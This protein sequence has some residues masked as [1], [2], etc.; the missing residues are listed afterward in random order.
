MEDQ[1]FHRLCALNTRFYRQTAASF[2]STRRSAWQGWERIAEIIEARLLRRRESDPAET[3]SVIDLAC[4]NMRFESFLEQRLPNSPFS[5]IA[6]DNCDSFPCTPVASP[7][8][9]A[10]A[11]LTEWLHGED[12]AGLPCLPPADLAVCFGFMHHIP[13]RKARAT[14][15]RRMA[16]LLA[17]GGIGAVSLW[18]FA[19]DPQMAAKAHGATAYARELLGLPDLEEGD[20]ILG[21]QNDE[22]AF[23]YCHSFSPAETDELVRTLGPHTRL[24]ERF[25]SDGR[26]GAL[27]T[28]LVFERER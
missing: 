26:T 8:E 23:R 9:F 5:F 3:L 24:L 18:D 20:Y 6:V 17:P 16:K 14:L 7:C 27:N 4:G 1:L 13:G 25:Q 2:S 12:G 15:L 19:Q 10:R 28:Y 11:D 21:W 22:D